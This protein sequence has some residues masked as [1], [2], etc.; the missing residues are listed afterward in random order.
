MHPYQSERIQGGG[1]IPA[2]ARALM[3]Y[4]GITKIAG[5]ISEETDGVNGIQPMIVAAEMNIP[6]IDVDLMCRAYPNVRSSLYS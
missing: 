4:I 1:E 3:K 6:I 5:T 2:S